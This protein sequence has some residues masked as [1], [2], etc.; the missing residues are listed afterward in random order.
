[1]QQDTTVLCQTVDGFMSWRLH[2]GAPTDCWVE[3]GGSVL[4]EAIPLE[5]EP[6]SWSATRAAPRV[7]QL[8][9]PDDVVDIAGRLGLGNSRDCER[10]PYISQG[11]LQMP[12]DWFWHHLS[13]AFVRRH[14]VPSSLETWAAFA[15]QVRLSLLPGRWTIPAE[16]AA[17]LHVAEGDY[18]HLLTRSEGLAVG[19]LSRQ[20]RAR[21][22]LNAPTGPH[23]DLLY[24]AARWLG[25]EGAANGVRIHEVKF[26][27][28]GPSVDLAVA[29]RSG[30]G[31]E[32]LISEGERDG[33]LFRMSWSG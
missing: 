8:S 33:D 11:I 16:L 31:R 25:Q 23:Q 26:Q 5:L 24:R 12:E 2:P 20:L 3:S 28:V 19:W 30:V 10:I 18:I 9:W 4:G 6:E 17:L 32:S 21:Y 29:G 7:N 14:S 22:D 15:G 1:M 27:S 13:L